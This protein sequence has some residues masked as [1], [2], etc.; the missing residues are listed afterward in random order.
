MPPES[1]GLSLDQPEQAAKYEAIIDRF[2]FDQMRLADINKWITDHKESTDSMRRSTR[3]P[4][5]DL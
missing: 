5:N 4:M 2:A 1:F 3:R